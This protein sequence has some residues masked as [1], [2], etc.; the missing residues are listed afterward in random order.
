MNGSPSLPRGPSFVSSSTATPHPS[1]GSPL[2]IGVGSASPMTPQSGALVAAGSS[3]PPRPPGLP[4]IPLAASLSAASS[5]PVVFDTPQEAERA[6]KGMLSELNV[7]STWNW[8][9]VMKEA[10]THPYYK[11]LKTLAE[12]KSAFEDYLREIREEEKVEREKS[13]AKWRKD[14][15]KALEK[16]NGGIMYEEGV[17]SWWSFERAKGVML[18]KVPEVW[19]GP[20]NDEERK[21]LF[22][23]FVNNLKQKEEVRRPHST[24]SLF[25]L[26]ARR[27]LIDSQT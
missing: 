22:T 26:T 23:D 12:R 2:A 11:S 24:Y 9:K 21:I 10:I 5:I 4:A 17:K 25:R 19:N 20:R 1:A 27:A 15:N 14:W 8:E 13:L 3:L 7:D 18:E 16:L 6:F